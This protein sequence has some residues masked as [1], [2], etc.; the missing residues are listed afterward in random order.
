MTKQEKLD[1]LKEKV[2]S[3]NKC[4]ELIQVRINHVFGEGNA[5]T[6]IV[7]LGEAP[8][9]NESEQGRPFVGRSGQL[10]TALLNSVGI[11][12]EDVY[13]LNILK[14]RPPENRKPKPE[15]AVACRSFLDMQLKIIQPE[16]IVCLG[17]SAANYLLGE[18]I[19]I[20]QMRGKWYE[21]NGAKVLCTF[22]P[23]YALRTGDYAKKEIKNDL[24]KVVAWILENPKT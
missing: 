13:I 17:A 15:E 12:R 3:C 20:G 8:G 11:Q 2:C 22:H 21:Y 24:E 5:N 9:L 10:L 6:R 4:E 18:K 7:C 19:P 23:S 14:C 16:I 1:L